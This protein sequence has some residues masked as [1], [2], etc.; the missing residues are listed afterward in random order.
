M[1]NSTFSSPLDSPQGLMVW[2]CNNSA[3]KLNLMGEVVVFWIPQFHRHALTS[4]KMSP[5]VASSNHVCDVCVA[6]VV[7]MGWEK[8][9]ILHSLGWL[10]TCLLYSRVPKSGSLGFFFPVPCQQVLKFA[11]S[12][13]VYLPQSLSNC[14]PLCPRSVKWSGSP[15]NA[16]A[17]KTCLFTSLLPSARPPDTAP[18][19]QPHSFTLHTGQNILLANLSHRPR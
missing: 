6:V 14:L 4:S 17:L 13:S 9:Q 18:P 1:H 3:A 5:C 16:C 8:E 2:C 12:A 15:A 7:F 11:Q 10:F 19:V